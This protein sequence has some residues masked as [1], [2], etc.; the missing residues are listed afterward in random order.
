MTSDEIEYPENPLPCFKCGKK[1]APVFPT[2]AADRVLY[3]GGACLFKTHGQYGSAVFDETDGRM[4][5]IN[6]CDECLAGAAGT[7]SIW[8]ARVVRYLPDTK[9]IPWRL[10]SQLPPHPDCPYNCSTLCGI[11]TVCDP[12]T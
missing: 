4:L 11:G 12:D 5:Y 7:G 2:H 3:A 9:V 8:L 1:L 10:A 6:I